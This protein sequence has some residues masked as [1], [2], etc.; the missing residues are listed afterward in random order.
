M[1]S[2]SKK[3]MSKVGEGAKY[4]VSFCIRPHCDKGFSISDLMTQ[5]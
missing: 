3:R 5:L 1:R 2:K 4:N